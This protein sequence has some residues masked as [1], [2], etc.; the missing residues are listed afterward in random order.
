MWQGR[1]HEERDVGMNLGTSAETHQTLPDGD[2]PQQRRLG[3]ERK[4]KRAK[5]LN[6]CH[7]FNSVLYMFSSC[8]TPLWPSE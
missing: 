8:Y 6:C 3:L 5:N 4:L 7:S 1:G 2:R